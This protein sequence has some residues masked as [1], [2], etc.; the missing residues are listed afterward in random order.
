MRGLPKTKL[1]T[2]LY[3]LDF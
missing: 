2:G 3:L 1:T